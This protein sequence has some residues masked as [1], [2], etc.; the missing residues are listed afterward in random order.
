V[1]RPFSEA[2]GV[3]CRGYSLLLQRRLTDFGA[4]KSFDRA[5]Q[6]V[7]EHSGVQVGASTVRRITEAHG[8]QLHGKAQL[9][10]GAPSEGGLA[11]IVAEIDG[12]MIPIVSLDPSQ[13]G[14]QRKARQIG[15]KEARLV[16]AYEPG[17]LE[18]LFGVSTGTV[19]QT[20]DQLGFCA[21]R[22]GWDATTRVH[23]VGDGAPWIADQTERLF[24][25]QGKLPG[26]FR[27]RVRLPCRGQ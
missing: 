3:H 1:C 22:L 9:V 20:G 15:W 18:P 8:Q 14:D 16:L 27:S 6:Q 25:A 13:E 26:R 19:T 4:D 5:A 24:G 23:T 21:A 7:L 10:Q 12:S 11:Q 2:A 17:V